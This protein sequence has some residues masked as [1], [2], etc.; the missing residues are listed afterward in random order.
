MF[1]PLARALAASLAACALAVQAHDTWFQPLSAEAGLLALGT[2]TR[3]PVQ[4]SGVG[5]EYLARQGCRTEGPGRQGTVALQPLRN[6]PKALVLRAPPGATTCWAQLTPFEIELPPA[7]VEVYF[8]DI[9]PPPA[10]REAWAALHAQGLPWRERYTKHAR[11]EL[12]APQ[13]AAT[14]MDMD[15]RLADGPP[16]RVGATLVAQALRDGQPLPGLALELRSED[17]PLGIWRRTDEQGRVR[18]PLPLPGRWVLRGTDLRLSANDATRWESRFV[19]LAF[20]VGAAAPGADAQ[21][22]R[23]LTLNALSTSQAAATTAISSEP[24]TSTARR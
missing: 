11:I 13:A 10:V 14:P 21:N 8:R 6:D 15:L 22:G 1:P 17:S 20:E 4:D 2:G 19:T 9:Q 23:N 18:I 3:Y 12:G 24:P 7:T 16:L 5:A